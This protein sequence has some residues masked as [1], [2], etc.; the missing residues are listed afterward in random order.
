MLSCSP[1][2]A[3]AV[4][5]SCYRR[6]QHD[7]TEAE[8]A[9]T[10]TLGPIS[11]SKQAACSL[12]QSV[13]EFDIDI[14]PSGKPTQGSLGTARRTNQ[15]KDEHGP[16]PTLR[17]ISLSKQTACCTTP[18]PSP[19]I[20]DSNAAISFLCAIAACAVADSRSLLRLSRP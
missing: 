17:S 14:C 19:A 12:L 20:L 9:R 18:S 13:H 2:V 6:A 1:T 15:V 11:P 10:P 4:A 8:Q 5:Y 3:C 7:P 16:R